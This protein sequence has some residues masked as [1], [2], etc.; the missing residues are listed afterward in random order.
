VIRLLPLPQFPA[1]LIGGT[2]LPVPIVIAGFLVLVVSALVRRSVATLVRA[3]MASGIVGLLGSVRA[4]TV[5]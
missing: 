2:V 3:I 4:V 5:W 1:F